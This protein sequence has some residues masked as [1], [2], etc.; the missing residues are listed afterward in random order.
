M[1]NT[2]SEWYVYISIL[3]TMPNA[4]AKRKL[5]LYTYLKHE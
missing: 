3:K 1:L 2:K 5:H 4:N